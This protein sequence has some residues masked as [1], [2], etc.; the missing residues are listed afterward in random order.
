MYN[1]EKGFYMAHALLEI[2]DVQKTMQSLRREAM[3][4]CT[5]VYAD[6]RQTVLCKPRG[7]IQQNILIS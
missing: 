2:K 4:H 5:F 6:P 1:Q 3:K 7:Q